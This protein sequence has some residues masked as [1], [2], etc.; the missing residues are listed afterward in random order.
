MVRQIIDLAGP[1]PLETTLVIVNPPKVSRPSA[2]TPILLD[3]NWD[4]HYVFS[5][6]YAPSITA[7]A[8]NNPMLLEINVTALEK[9]GVPLPR[10][11]IAII[12]AR[13]GTLTWVAQGPTFATEA[14]VA[15]HGPAHAFVY[16]DRD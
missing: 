11:N 15:P 1:L 8:I 6:I 14:H 5:L 4:L 2:I 13:A 3:L 16:E 12:D 7:L 9:I 10:T